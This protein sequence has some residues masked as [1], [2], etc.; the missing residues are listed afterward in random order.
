ML[1]AGYFRGLARR[2][3]TLARTAIVPEIKEQLRLWAVEFADQADETERE[4]TDTHR[5]ARKSDR[6]SFCRRAT[7]PKAAG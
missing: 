3:R 6:G 5:V 4:E 2:C 7:G 1:D